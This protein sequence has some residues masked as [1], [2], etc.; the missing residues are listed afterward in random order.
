VRSSLN[1]QLDKP[2]K[3]VFFCVA[4]SSFCALRMIT[5]CRVYSGDSNFVFLEQS[6]CKIT[7]PPLSD[8]NDLWTSIFMLNGA[9]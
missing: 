9:G 7:A 8:P 3:G 6:S 2:V 4:S 5:F 1:R